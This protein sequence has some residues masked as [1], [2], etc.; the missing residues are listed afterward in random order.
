MEVFAS[1]AS[2]K[3]KLLASVVALDRKEGLVEINQRQPSR[4]TPVKERA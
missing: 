3:D 2:K 4:I 1:V